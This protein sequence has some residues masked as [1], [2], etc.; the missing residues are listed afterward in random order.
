MILYP[1]S[2]QT[3]RWSMRGGGEGGV[4]GGGGGGVKGL[5]PAKND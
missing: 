5:C 2:V 4:E 1:L 3:R